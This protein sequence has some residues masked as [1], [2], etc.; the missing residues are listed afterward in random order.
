[1]PVYIFNNTGFGTLTLCFKSIR[2]FLYD[3]KRLK[4]EYKPVVKE[5][6]DF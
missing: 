6:I 3:L 1:M 5:N 4:Y 2:I